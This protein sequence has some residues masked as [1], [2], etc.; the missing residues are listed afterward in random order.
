MQIERLHADDFRNLVAVDL[1][2]HPRF[3]LIE[4][5]NGQGKT[6]IL[7]TIYLLSGLRSF[8]TARLAECVRFDAAKA[9]LAARL[10]RGGVQSDLGLELGQ[11]RNRVWLD[12]KVTRRNADY[13]GRLI[14]VMFTPD[15]LRLPHAE[16]GARRR[17]LDRAV[18]NHSPGYL[19]ELRRYERA[20][21]QR[22]ALLRDVDGRGVDLELL[23]VFDDLVAEAGSIVC[24]RRARFVAEFSPLVARHFSEVASPEL[25]ASLL[26]KSAVEVDGAATADAWRQGLK[27]AL[28]AGRRR[29]IGRRFTGIGPH[30]DD[31]VLT[32][33]D[34]PA[35]VHASQGQ[36]RALILAMKIAE[37]RSLEARLGEAPV[38]LMDDVS[39]ELDRH[40]NQALMTHLDDLG[41]QVFLTTTDARH[42][43]L[44]APRRVF[45]MTQGRCAAVTPQEQ[46][47][48]AG[49]SD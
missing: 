22:N 20:L 21:S 47:S 23:T 12:G 3:N 44:T 19:D 1:V 39:S 42:I 30:T 10:V 8:R 9:I 27:E 2:P 34:R 24:E 13:L 16:P 35:R 4:G 18:F 31:L 41:G 45:R 48:D 37:I 33:Q 38:L 26:L 5:D 29:D 49:I 6:N 36:C 32:I 7:E 25:A 43:A 46:D 28:V 11:R 15:D 40:R 14:V 17:Y